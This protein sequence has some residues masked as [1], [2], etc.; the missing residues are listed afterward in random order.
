MSCDDHVVSNG[1]QAES[2]NKPGLYSDFLKSSDLA[3]E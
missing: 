2:S 1:G 3:V